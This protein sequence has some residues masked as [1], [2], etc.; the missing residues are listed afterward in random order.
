MPSVM[1]IVSKA[2]FERQAHAA[3]LEGLRAILA[4]HGELRRNFAASALQ[5]ASGA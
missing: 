1:A 5:T 3:E 4:P 2:V